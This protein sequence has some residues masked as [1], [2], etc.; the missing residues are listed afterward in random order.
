MSLETFRTSTPVARAEND[1]RQITLHGGGLRLRWRG[2]GFV[3]QRPL[4]VVV[5]W[6]DEIYHLPIPDMT[7]RA[8]VAIWLA[9]LLAAGVLWWRQRRAGRRQTRQTTRG[10][11]TTR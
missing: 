5:Q 3:W 2:G 8:M 1:P 4:V 7:W 11:S 9:G 6:D 10:R